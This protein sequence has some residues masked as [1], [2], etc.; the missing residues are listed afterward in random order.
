MTSGF[1]DALSSGHDQTVSAK[2]TD[3]TPHAMLR[4]DTRAWHDRVEAGF[5]PFDLQQFEGLTGFLRRQA[6]AVLPIEQELER[7]GIGDLLR[8]WPNR[9]RGHAL[10]ADLEQLGA[11]APILTATISLPSRLHALGALYVLEGSRLG[12]RVLAR[13]VAASADPRVRTAVR[14]LTHRHDQGWSSFLAILDAVPPTPST[15]ACLRDGATQ[16]FSLFDA[17][18]DEIPL[19]S[20]LVH[21]N[22]A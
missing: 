4:R 5:A 17:A 13:R 20:G 21:F 19:R 7:I 11:E 10:L 12:G 3:E 14:F 9:R 18:P 1:S 22:N 8:D 6:M 15:L 2:V 16:A